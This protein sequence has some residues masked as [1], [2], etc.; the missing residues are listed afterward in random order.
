M[1]QFEKQLVK[2][3]DFRKTN[4]QNQNLAVWIS[5]FGF[6]I[7]LVHLLFVATQI[8]IF[9]FDL[10]VLIPDLGSVLSSPRSFC[11]GFR[12][13]NWSHCFCLIAGR[14]HGFSTKDS[15]LQAEGLLALQFVHP[16]KMRYQ[17]DLVTKFRVM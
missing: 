17:P 13:S 5:N 15:A 9:D 8:W 7:G 12:V 1:G 16:G 11:F 10:I 4:L 14:L 6:G 3:L 2:P